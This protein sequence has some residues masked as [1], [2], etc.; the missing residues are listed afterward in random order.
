MFKEYHLAIT[1]QAL[2]GRFSQTALDAILLANIHQDR[3]AG[4]IG[5][6]EYHFD[7]NA[8][9]PGLAYIERNRREV[10]A[11]LERGDAPAA[12]RAFGRLTHAA[13]DFYAHSNYVSLWLDRFPPHE[14]PPPEEIEPLD[15]ALL[16]GPLRSGKIYWPL[17]PLS[18]IP[19]LKRFIVPLLPP[20]SHARMNLDWPE[21]GPKFAYAFAAAV[22]RT[23]HEYEQT[24]QAL[25]PDL[26]PLFHG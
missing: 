19:L 23:A 11:A 9:A 24:A 3:P 6:P 14:W 1:A 5:H 22:K 15:P 8:F 26:L 4:Q 20:D 10:R 7:D 2:D 25:P 12:W 16:A 21:R 17:E 18:W 13:Q